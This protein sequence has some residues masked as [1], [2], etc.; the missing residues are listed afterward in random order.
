MPNKSTACLRCFLK[1][2][3]SL[4]TCETVGVLNTITNLISSIQVN[5][6]MKMILNKESNASEHRLR[7]RSQLPEKNLL[8]FDI[9]KNELLKIRIKKNENCVCCVKNN[10]EYLNGKKSSKII[11]L[12]G[13]NIYQIKTKA[14]DKKTFN[15]IK[16]KLKRI[17]KV[18]DFG[19]SINFN[20]KLTIFNDGRALI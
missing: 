6:A 12:C 19:Y 15:N 5:E 4:D 14:I 8:F 13:D 10:F 1:E 2:A 9:W 18:I 3:A 7:T 17:G 20:E 16:N 11:K